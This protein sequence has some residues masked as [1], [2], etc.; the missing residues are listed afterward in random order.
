MSARYLL[1]WPVVHDDAV[2]AD[3]G[4][5][6]DA[7]ARRLLQL[8]NVVG[9]DVLGAVHLALDQR[10]LLRRALPDDLPDVA[11]ELPLLGPALPVAGVGDE[12]VLGA[13]PPVLGVDLEGPRARAVVRRARP[14]RRRPCR[15]PSRPSGFTTSRFGSVRSKS[16]KGLVSLTRSVWLS[17]TVRLLSSMIGS[18]IHA[19]P[20]LIFEDA[21]ESVLDGLGGHRRAVLELRRRRQLDRPLA[22]VRR[23]A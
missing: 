14:G 18:H 9:G 17:T 1:S 3:A 12:L 8:G 19:G 10:Q 11:V 23:R 13:V 6:L 16:E 5:L 20:F 4:V 21:L 15:W 7:H 22:G 2:R